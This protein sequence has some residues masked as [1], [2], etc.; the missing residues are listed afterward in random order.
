MTMAATSTGGT[1]HSEDRLVEAPADGPACPVWLRPAPAREGGEGDR[2]REERGAVH[3]GEGSS[4]G[5]MLAQIPPPGL[6]VRPAGRHCVH[7]TRLSVA[8]ALAARRL[9]V[10]GGALAASMVAHRVAVG[11]L[12]VTA[13]TPVVWMGLLAMVAVVGPRRRFRPRGF[14]ACAAVICVAQMGVHLAMGVVP[15]AFGLVPH[16]APGLAVGPAA[17]AAHAVAAA[18]CWRPPSCGWRGSSPG[19]WP[20][21]GA[22][23]AG[24]R[25]RR[26]GRAPRAGPRCAPS[27]RGPR[28]G[29]PR[30]AAGRPCCVRHDPGR[31]RSSGAARPHHE[32][33]TR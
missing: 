4:H 13:A 2:Q 20:S 30:S 29:D 32:W 14:A 33:R 6:A 11:D 9:A 18:S 1:A 21:A 17:L 25:R 22:C 12:D 5:W 8:N 31:P 7:V 27:R 10:A 23:G 19:R 16:H 15:W 28:R 26:A 24:S 3:Q